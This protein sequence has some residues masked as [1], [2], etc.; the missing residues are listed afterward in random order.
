[1]DKLYTKKDVAKLLNCSLS[2]IN[3][4]LK[5]NKIPYLKIEKNVRFHME[6]LNNWL[7]NKKKD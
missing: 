1:M 4:L 2:K 5:E 7:L 6:D 3:I